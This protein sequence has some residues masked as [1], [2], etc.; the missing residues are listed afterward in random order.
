MGIVEW[1][2]DILKG[3]WTVLVGMKVTMRHMVSPTVTMHYPDEKWVMPENFRGLLKCDIDACIVCDLCAKACPVDCI[4]IEW[5]REEGKSGKV[6]TEFTIDYNTC[7]YCGLCVEPCPTNAIWHSHE[8]ENSSYERGA[9]IID[10][11]LPK[12]IVTNPNAKPVGAKAAPKPA[13]AKTSAPATA[14]ATATAA[15]PVKGAPIKKV[16]IIEG[17]IVC[18]VCE[19][20]SP[21]VFK[22]GETTSVVLPLA[23]YSKYSDGIIEAAT[24]C[25]VNVIKYE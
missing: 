6:C 14:T 18:D 25:P 17:C 11:A 19:D 15:P 22:V 21:D 2:R 16:W 7:M 4:T 9:Q 1:F 20:A 10:W 13:L 5:K 12:N 24:G 3:F 8:Y 23:D